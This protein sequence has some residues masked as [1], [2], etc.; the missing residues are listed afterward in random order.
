MSGT[1]GR[2]LASE[3][4]KVT[5]TKM[6]V[7][8]TLVA[9]AFACVNVVTLVLV[10]SGIIP[11]VPVG[12]GGNL[13]LDPAYATTLIGQSSGASTFVL[14]LGVIAMTGEFRHMTI[15][16]T[17][18]ASPRRTT[19]L[20]SKMVLFAVLGVLIAVL[21]VAVVLVVAL[22]SLAG[23]EHAPIAASAV[24]SVLVGAVV[25]FA[26]YAVLGVSLGALIKNQVAAIV[27]A[28]VWVMLVEAIV[29]VAFP[30][31]G[32]WLPAGALNSAMDISLSSDMTGQLTV[33]DR[34]PSW[35]GA[36]VLLAYALVLAAIASRTTLRRDI[37]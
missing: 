14:L 20:A 3:W 30:A 31:V 19:V 17:F 12:E 28:L 15:T 23:F 4:R 5:T 11:G 24:L 36:L 21:T 32:K 16:S 29:T 25:G 6:A 10:A 37:T 26:L 1:F 27:T 7:A 2:Q 35:G 13:L 9:I 8:L 22:I 34:L 18:L 33:A